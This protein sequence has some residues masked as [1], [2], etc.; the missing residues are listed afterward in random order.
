MYD[1]HIHSHHSADG[2]QSLREI[3]LGAIQN[4]VQEVCITSHYDY[5]FP[6]G[7]MF[8]FVCDLIDYVEDVERYAK[9]YAPKV[10]IRTGVEIGMQAGR[11]DIYA[12]TRQDMQGLRFDFIL[13]SI[14]W[15]GFADG[16]SKH[17]IEPGVN[18]AFGYG[19]TPSQ[20]MQKYATQLL[21]CAK[22]FPE[23]DVIGHLT[24]HSRHNPYP[25]KQLRYADAPEQIDALFRYLITHGKGIEIN[26]SSKSS[27]GFFMPDLDIVQRYAQLGGEIVTIGS[28][29]HTP[30]RI[31][32]RY[33]DACALLRA[34][35]LKYVCTFTDHVPAFHT[36]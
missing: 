10:I 31:G 17:L 7:R 15:M 16:N 11:E 20:V 3:A 19:A 4:G 14:H 30:D 22:E 21:Q 1:Y 28:D 24:Y 23:L 9:R 27:L 13:G 36:I 12:R 32:D 2:K 6:V 29:A 34:A 26:T 25:D 35:G 18:Q 5:D 8:N 33:A